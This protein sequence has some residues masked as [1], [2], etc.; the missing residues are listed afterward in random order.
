V[1]SFENRLQPEL[2]P[3]THVEVL[4]R[5]QRSWT[6]GFEVEAV[7]RRGYLLRRQ[8]DGYVLPIAIP[9]RH[10]RPQH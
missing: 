4:T 6:T 3:G 1:A 8:S 10:V 2:L 5:Y 7:D 9:A